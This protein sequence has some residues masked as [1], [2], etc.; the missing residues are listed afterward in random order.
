MTLKGYYRNL[1]AVVHPKTDFLNEVARRANVSTTTVRNWVVYGMKPKN[2]QHRSILS[3][4]TGIPVD[5]LWE[6]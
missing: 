1:D 6:E 2:E 5:N 4:V 3:E